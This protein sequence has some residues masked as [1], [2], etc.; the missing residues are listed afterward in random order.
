MQSEYEKVIN[1]FVE[2]QLKRKPI[3]PQALVVVA[4][5]YLMAGHARSTM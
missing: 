4:R 5:S 1:E 3:S 2:L